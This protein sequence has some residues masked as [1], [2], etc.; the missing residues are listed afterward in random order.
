MILYLEKSWH[1]G[2]HSED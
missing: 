2:G 1:K